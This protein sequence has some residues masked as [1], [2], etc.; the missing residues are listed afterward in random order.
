MGLKYY[1]PFTSTRRHMSVVDSAEITRPS[2]EKS[3][4]RGKKSTGG[5]NNQGK[6]TVRFRG[7]GV[8]KSY[9]LIDFRREK[10]EIPAKVKSIEY[11]P[12]RSAHI[13][14]LN[15]ADG[16]KRYILA[17]VGLKEGMSVI[18]S[19]K[20]APFNPGNSMPLS[21]V[22][23]GITIHN[24]ELVPG[25]GAKLVRSA[26]QQAILRA[27]EGKYGQVRLPSGEIRLINLKCM[28]TIGQVSNVDHNEN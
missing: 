9:R 21:M 2:S 16:E 7:G 6:M 23:P 28:A 14:L 18:A 4:V 19:R 8:K 1:K 24:I 15:Y 13:A 5:R 11:D 10:V 20:N 27:K 17:P 22:P 3:L 12:N 26:G 25:N